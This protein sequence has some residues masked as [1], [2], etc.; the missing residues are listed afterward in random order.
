MKKVAILASGTGSNAKRIIQHFE[1]IG[2]DGID[3]IVSSNPAAGVLRHGTDHGIDTMVLKMDALLNGSF[4]SDLKERGIDLIV[5]AGFLWKIPDNVLEAYP[6]RIVNI[7]PSLLPKFGGKGMYGNRVHQAV[8]ATG[9]SKSGITIH[10]VNENYDEGEHIFQAEC[11]VLPDD[12]P[13][14]LAAR[15]LKLEHEHFPLI[16]EKLVRNE[17]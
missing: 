15:V 5:L 9:E 17:L 14:S 3:L 8:V 7:H 4:V 2:L 6:D 1:R 11:E 10:Y 12:D 16:V 13:A